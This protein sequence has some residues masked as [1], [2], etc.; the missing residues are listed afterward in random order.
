MNTY[1]NADLKGFCD[2]VLVSMGMNQENAAVVA[3][4][5]LS[6]NLEGVDSHGISRLPIYTKRISDGRINLNPNIQINVKTPSV[7]LVDGDNGLGH[8]VSYQAIQKGIEVTKE[9]GITA[10]AVK[11]SNH[12]GTASYFCQLACEQDLACIGFTNSPS[13]IAPWGGKHAFF[14]T[15][16]IAFGF[17][18]GNDQPV[19]IDLSTSIVARGKIILAAKQG[20]RIPDGWAIDEHGLPTND[21]EAALKGSVLPLGGAKGAALALAVEILTGILSGAAFGPHVKNLYDDKE[22]G[23]ANVGHFFILL[24]IAK[25]MDLSL[26]FKSLET[27]L[28][29]MKAVPKVPGTTEIRYPGERRKREKEQRLSEGIQLS[30]NVEEEL[31]ELGTKF[32]VLFPTPIALENTQ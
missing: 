10:I 5:L 6:A 8:V 31:I 4:A 23:Q 19:I 22:I 12:F 9:T 30:T 27:L 15:N 24:D 25:F 20:D 28:G 26:F 11:N 17:P 21:P 29:E 7:L 14:G 2:D 16:P 32:N 18:T 1:S 3:E 13:G